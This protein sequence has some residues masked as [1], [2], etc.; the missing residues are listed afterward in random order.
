ML[1]GKTIRAA[2]EPGITDISCTLEEHEG[3]A[4]YDEVFSISWV[5]YEPAN[6]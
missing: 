4:H 2:L 6:P 3:N 1:C 5:E